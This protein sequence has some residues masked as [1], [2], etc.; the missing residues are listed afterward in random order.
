MIEVPALVWQLDQLLPELDFVSIGSNDLVQFLYASDRQNP[1]LAQRYDPLSP[2]VLKAIR[3]I[4][5]AGEAHGV[6]VNLCGEMAGRPL[7]AMALVRPRP[8][9]DLHG[10]CG[11]R[12]GQD[13]DPV[14]RPGKIMGLY[15]AA[16]SQAGSFFAPGAHLLRQVPGHPAAFN[17]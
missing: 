4:V 11:D 12:T 17:L 13:H 9:I 14:D 8:H 5:E 3:M 16:S 1:R 6:H 7:E 2:A 10:P 15:G